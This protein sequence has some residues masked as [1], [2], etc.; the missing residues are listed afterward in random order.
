MSRP[1]SANPT[2]GQW[3]FGEKFQPGMT[4][5]LFD[6]LTVPYEPQRNII[7]DFYRNGQNLTNT[8]TLATN[9]EKGGQG[10]ARAWGA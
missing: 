1:T 5:V 9:G 7:R 8:L 10:L 3:S 6:N 4:H 2:S